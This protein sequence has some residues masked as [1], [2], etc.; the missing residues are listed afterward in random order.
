MIAMLMGWGLSSRIAKLVGYVII[1]LVVVGLL[2]WLIS[3]RISAYGER[4]FDAG[5]GNERAKW[6]EAG[7]KL[8]LDA[9]AS[10]TKADDRAVE[11]LEQH[12][13]QIDEDQKA[14]DQAV[15]DGSSPLDAL[16]GS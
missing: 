11:R 7:E 12:K 4:Q 6:V 13:E 14:V 2:F 5:V 3:S 16:F 9:E 15:R 10:A 1:P 8:K